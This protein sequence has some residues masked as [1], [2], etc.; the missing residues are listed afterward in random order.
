MAGWVREEVERQLQLNGFW[1]D[2][3]KTSP[4]ARLVESSLRAA[5][6]KAARLAEDRAD[7]WF[8]LHVVPNGGWLS[9]RGRE[10]SRI[11]AEL[12]A[13]EDVEMEPYGLAAGGWDT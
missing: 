13:L 6:R 12:R 3:W 11:A 8:G 2:G 7:H 9:P 10:A 5:L 1:S 4:E